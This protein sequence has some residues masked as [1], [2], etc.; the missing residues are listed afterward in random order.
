M[1]ELAK[2]NKTIV[3]VVG[4]ALTWAI[5]TYAGDPEVSKWLSLVA[6]VLTAAGVYQVPN[7]KAV[8]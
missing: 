4:A 2:Y 3:A 7:R 6:A 1:H 8:K 5:A